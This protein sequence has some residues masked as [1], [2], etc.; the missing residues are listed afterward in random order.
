MI[1]SG[2]QLVPDMSDSVHHPRGGGRRR[3]REVSLT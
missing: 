1:S 3:G 2:N